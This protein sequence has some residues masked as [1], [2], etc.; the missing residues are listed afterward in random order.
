M[1][2][3]HYDGA[4]VAKL[5]CLSA[6]P[7]DGMKNFRHVDIIVFVQNIFTII[8]NMTSLASDFQGNERAEKLLIT[9]GS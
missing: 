5:T 8:T 3:Y 2:F 4:D 9:S 7:I 1:T 6:F